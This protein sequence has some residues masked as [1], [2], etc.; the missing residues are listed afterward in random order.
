MIKEYP[1]SVK[2]YTKEEAPYIYTKYAEEVAKEQAGLEPRIAGT[3]ACFAGQPLQHGI[4][5][6]AWKKSGFVVER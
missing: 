3:I 1:V 6:K 5:A 2:D 4:T